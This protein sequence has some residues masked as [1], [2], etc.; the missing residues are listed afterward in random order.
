MHSYLRLTVALSAAMTTAALA[1]LG[2]SQRPQ[3]PQGLM[4]PSRPALVCGTDG[5]VATTRGFRPLAVSTEGQPLWFTQEPSI[6]T[7]DYAGAVTLSNFVVSGDVATLRFRSAAPLNEGDIETWTRTE[8]QT[9]NGRLVSVF[10]PVWGGDALSRVLSSATFGWDQP[11]LDWGEVLPGETLPGEGLPLGLRISPRNLQTSA[12]VQLSGDVQYS[13]NIVNLR[14]PGYGASRLG[15][16]QDDYDATTVAQMF[17]QH[18]ED[19]YDVLAIVPHDDHLAPY[20]AFHST[21]K[22]E[23]SGIGQ[24]LVDDSASYGSAGRL[25]AYEVYLNASVTDNATS[26]HETAHQWGSYFDWTTLTGLVRAG[27]Q[28]EA[29]SPLWA[30]GETLMAGLLEPTRRL[31]VVDGA[32]QVV[33]TPRLA[34]FHPFMKYAMGIIPAD[35]VPEV[36]LFDE[37]GQFGGNRQPD[38]GTPVAGAARTATVF[39]AI[40]MLGERQGPVPV[41]WQRA[42]IVVTRDR[43]LTQAEMDYWTFFARRIED[44]FQSG[45]GTWTGIPSFDFSTDRAID[46]VT[47][48][49][50]KVAAPLISTLDVNYPALDATSW[51]G[52]R[53]DAPIKTSYAAGERVRLSGQ[54]TAT[55]RTDFSQILLIFFPDTALPGEVLQ[56]RATVSAAGTF[57]F[58]FQFEAQHVGTHAMA[59]YLFWPGAP[60]QF[61]RSVV[62]PIVVAAAAATP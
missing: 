29:H 38:A 36:T 44:P 53:F 33:R 31:D 41:D 21:L 57:I 60:N 32:W 59:A 11:R 24:P 7:P 3:E 15:E 40:G 8:T 22:N 46:L 28:A 39:N 50:P 52:V 49:R 34:L 26:S 2:A 13:S 19:S 9:I 14:I 5:V 45:V 62:T 30:A 54:V 6:L 47:T 55:D 56:T 58:D 17:Y 23:V 42:T 48:I 51:R 35:A 16:D 25:K 20:A 10:N 4:P 43:L 1:T 61:P 27:S 12:V 18:F 37:Q